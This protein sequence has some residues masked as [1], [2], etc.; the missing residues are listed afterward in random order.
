MPKKKDEK[1]TG[2]Q[3][4]KSVSTREEKS[5]DKADRKPK[6]GFVAGAVTG[7][8]A[9]KLSSVVQGTQ[10]AYKRNIFV[11]GGDDR[12]MVVPRA[13]TGLYCLDAMTNGGLPFGRVTMLMGPAKGG[14][15]TTYMRSLGNAQKLCANCYKPGT[16]KRGIIRLPNLQTGE[17]EDVETDV[18]CEC[19]CGNPRDMIVLWVDSEGVF[20]STWAQKM[21]VL[22]EK[23]ILLR[24]SYGEQAYDTITAFVSVKEIDL[25][26]IDSIAA[27]TPSAEYEASMEEN[28]QGVAARMNNRFIRKIVSGMNEAFQEDRP[29]TVWMVNQ[30]REKIGVMWGNP[31]CLPGGK[32]QEFVT[33]VE[34]ELR[35]GKT[36]TDPD[37]GEP[38]KCDFS[39]TVKKN[40]VGVSGGKGQFSQ[41]AM[42]T[43]LFKV[44]DLLEH[45]DVVGKAVELGIV[46][47]PGQGVYEYNGETYRGISKLVRYLA[48]NVQYYQFLKNQMLRLKLRIQ[49][50]E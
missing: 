24:P 15:T 32:G 41:S 30:Y 29:I 48:E 38:I 19:P 25:I 17:V 46:K 31:E 22:P 49:T 26:V 12:V 4:E 1:K 18:I 34:I 28:Q 37:N 27:L 3:V 23:I 40:K 13:S 33:S 2:K 21:G 11:S 16:F 6:K 5:T 14:K 35:P 47:N 20:L 10:K 36:H 42:D 50:K 8:R 7:D 9:D 44:G 43:D 39:F 45:E